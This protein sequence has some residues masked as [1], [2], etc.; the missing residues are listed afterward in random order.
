MTLINNNFKIKKILIDHLSDFEISKLRNNEI[1]FF[2]NKKILITGAS[3]IIGLNL[4]FFF[5]KLNLEKKIKIN[6]DATYNTSI[7]NF[8]LDYFKK[9][10]KIKFIKIDLTNKK[11]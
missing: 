9:N 7:F 6:I 2:K 11:N 10:K 4:L 8:V 5:N 1:N 3:G